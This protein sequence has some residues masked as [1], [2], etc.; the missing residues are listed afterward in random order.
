MHRTQTTRDRAPARPDPVARRR[1]GILVP[2]VLGGLT[3]LP[4]LSMDMYLPALQEVNDALAAP[5]ATA[6]LTLTA[7]LLGMALGQL[8]VGPMTDRWGRRRPLLIGMTV[9]AAAT[10]VCV[11]APTVELLIAGRLLQGLAGAAGLVTVVV[12]RWLH[13]TL[14][15]ERRHSGGVG[16]AL[17]T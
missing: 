4:S 3:A 7:Y 17:H 16:H 5:T 2:L 12:A 14:P 8:A 9:Y 6:Q 10:A 13:E 15:Q 1:T 11:V